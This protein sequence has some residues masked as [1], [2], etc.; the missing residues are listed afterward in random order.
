MTPRFKLVKASLIAIALL[1][2]LT[3]QLF[4]DT[5]RRVELEVD[6][7]DGGKETIVIEPPVVAFSS[8]AF[9][10]AAILTEESVHV[11]NEALA[12]LGDSS[13]DE[14]DTFEGSYLAVVSA[15][16]FTNVPAEHADLVAAYENGIGKIAS[17]ARDFYLYCVNG[18]GFSPFNYHLAVSGYGEAASMLDGVVRAAFER[19]GPAEITPPSS[20]P[21]AE[22][23]APPPS[24][25][26]VAPP[27]EA[28]EPAS[29]EPDA[30]FPG[31]QLYFG[32]Q[33]PTAEPRATLILNNA[34]GTTRE[35]AV[36]PNIVP[37]NGNDFTTVAIVTSSFV[38]YLRLDV[39]ASMGNQSNDRCNDLIATY[40]VLVLSPVFSDVP[41][42]YAP[43]VGEYEEM[44]GQVVS[45]IKDLTQW[46]FNQGP[47]PS[48][49][50]SQALAAVDAVHVQLASLV[51]RAINA[52]G[53]PAGF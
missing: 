9:M 22:T 38:D 1:V 52:F 11:G 16:A 4:A 24:E 14:C 17:G 7:A 15:P 19:F 32:N 45:G 44:V 47:F 33:Y 8:N 5:L 41:E 48:F 10:S 31:E 28:E 6:A 34:D 42:Q 35:V 27:V 43:W 23:P 46:C 26:P 25:E 36:R 20:P 53:I 21:P 3:G 51:Q 39:V 50:Y 40:N 18:G 12:S 29:P 37:F 30:A 49:S 2:V 13:T